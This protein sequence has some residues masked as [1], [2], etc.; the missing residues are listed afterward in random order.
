[1]AKKTLAEAA[2]EVLDASR[3]P[4]QPMHKLSDTG[5]GLDAVRD[6]GGSSY[7]NPTDGGTGSKSAAGA[8]SAT[9]PGTQ[10][11]AGTK[12]P[13]H[14]QTKGLDPNKGTNKID[15]VAAMDGHVG[16]TLAKEEED[17]E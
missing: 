5:S 8:P 6:I 14:V 7:A 2:K 11:D 16:H 1:M 4:G 13:M 15:Q 9:P 17:L 10:P 12:E 3:V